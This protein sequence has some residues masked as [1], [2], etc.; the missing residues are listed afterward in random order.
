M[1]ALARMLVRYGVPGRFATGA[2]WALVALL[3]IVLLS[4]GK[5]AYD[6]SVISA[7]EARRDVAIA[8]SIAA[9]ERAAAKAGERIG[10]EQAQ[11]Q[12]K[13]MEAIEHA[14]QRDPAGAARPVGP[15]TSAIADEL[16]RQASPR[17][18]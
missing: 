1:I 8:E 17:G 3:A 14:E 9:G 6:R 11:A 12:T 16:R 15:A 2:T 13:A 18:R 7:H 10:A 4:V 5:C